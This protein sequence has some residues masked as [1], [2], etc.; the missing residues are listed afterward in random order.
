MFAC[1]DK[2]AADGEEYD[3]SY[4]DYGGIDIFDARVRMKNWYAF[5]FFASNKNS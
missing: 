1:E 3:N 2:D 5:F 4:E